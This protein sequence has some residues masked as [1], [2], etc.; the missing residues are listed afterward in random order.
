MKISFASKKEKKQIEI[1]IV[2]EKIIGNDDWVG[3]ISESCWDLEIRIDG[4][5]Y[6]YIHYGYNE[7]H[8]INYVNVGSI[9]IAIPDELWLDVKGLIDWYTLVSIREEKKE[10]QM[11]AKH[12]AARREVEN[13][14]KYGHNF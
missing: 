4:K 14:S 11:M 3:N 10:L 5:L 2:T 13:M 9:N 8:Q 7:Q 6:H 1:A 12:S